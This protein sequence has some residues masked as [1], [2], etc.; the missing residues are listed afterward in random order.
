[1]LEID[2]PAKPP[3]PP[4]D[5]DALLE[6][7][8]ATGY[9]VTRLSCGIDGGVACGGGDDAGPGVSIG[10][11]VGTTVLPDVDPGVLIDNGDAVG[12]AASVSALDALLAATA[13]ASLDE[14]GGAP[15]TPAT[16]GML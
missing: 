9:C 4:L 2:G 12:A 3:P 15:G 13:A 8:L 10:C 1:M 6:P 14:T 16:T 5:D 11:C 7:L